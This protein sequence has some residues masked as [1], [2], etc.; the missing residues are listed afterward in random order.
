MVII[1]GNRAMMEFDGTAKLQAHYRDVRSRLYGVEK[2][3]PHPESTWLT[4]TI[5]CLSLTDL[6]RDIVHN[7]SERP[8]LSEIRNRTEHAFGLTKDE[9]IEK[10]RCVSILRPRQIGMTL[11]RALIMGQ[12]GSLRI[13][14]I[15]FGGYDHST[16]LNAIDRCKALVLDAIRR[17]GLVHFRELIGRKRNRNRRDLC[18]K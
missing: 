6:T 5:T 11:S 13:I 12:Y 18:L 9:M 8:T 2:R 17:E 15:A 16:V 10:N 1:D 7:L 3:M 14:G 4:P